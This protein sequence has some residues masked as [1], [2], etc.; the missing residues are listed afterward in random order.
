MTTHSRR[1]NPASFLIVILLMAL[2]AVVTYYL[3][4]NSE[5]QK[6]EEIVETKD[7]EILELRE[8]MEDLAR[9]LDA[10]IREAKKLGADYKALQEYKDQLEQ[11]L[12]LLQKIPI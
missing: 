9:D 5:A 3:V 11:D 8:K 1:P 6:Q 4:K 12:S 2:T 10:K 7:K